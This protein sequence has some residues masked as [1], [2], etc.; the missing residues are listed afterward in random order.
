MKITHNSID[1]MSALPWKIGVGT[2]ALSRW[3]AS[4]SSNPDTGPIYRREP[5]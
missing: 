3:T 1:A 5:L 2:D 4:L